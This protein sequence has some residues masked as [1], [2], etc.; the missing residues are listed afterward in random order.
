MRLPEGIRDQF[1]RYGSAGGKIRARR[2]AAGARQSVARFAALRR[3]TRKRF[4][5]P[6][7]AELGLPGGDLVDAG[8]SDLAMQRETVGSLLLAVAEPRLRREGVPLP[9]SLPTD[10]E[11]KLFRLLE[12]T[13]EGLAHA[14]YLAYIQQVTSFADACRTLHPQGVRRA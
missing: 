12:R 4:G 7:F 13:N 1:A 11:I 10:P 5:D 8:L 3:W 14:R 6:S 2:M 9:P